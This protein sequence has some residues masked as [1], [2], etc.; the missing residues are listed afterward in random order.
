MRG[1]HAY[2]EEA[3]A[4]QAGSSPHAR[5]ALRELVRERQE[6]GI[7]PACAGST[8]RSACRWTAWGDHPRMRGEHADDASSAF[9]AGGSSP[10]ARGAHKR[11]VLDGLDQGIIPA[12]AGSTRIALRC[13]R[14]WRDHPRMRGEH[15]GKPAAQV[16]AM[17]SSPHARGAHGVPAM[18][19]SV[20]WII[21]ACAG[22]TTWAPRRT[23]RW[24]DHP[25]MRG[26]HLWRRS[27]RA[28]AAGSSPHARGARLGEPDAGQR[29]GIIPACAGS[30]GRCRRKPPWCRDHPRMRGEHTFNVD[31]SHKLAGSSPHAR[32]ARVQQ[33]R[34]PGPDGIIPACAGSTTGTRSATRAGRD[35]PRMRGEHSPTLVSV[36][37]SCG[38]SPHARGARPHTG[39]RQTI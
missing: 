9:D 13:R 8:T 14:A 15:K 30:T 10:H 27:R 4:N 28:C 23:R 29:R 12:C 11:A 34:L 38:S 21:P 24:R 36:S 35:H 26:E 37:L 31:A 33:A 6:L 18:D 1:E 7:I 3:G 16:R 2:A 32:G 20:S 39:P 22:S 25:R 17:G 19:V 5:G